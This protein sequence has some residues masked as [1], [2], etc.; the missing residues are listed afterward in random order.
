MR[1]GVTIFVFSS[2]QVIDAVPELCAE[3]E[4]SCT[5]GC[6]LNPI[7]VAKRGNLLFCIDD[8]VRN[9]DILWLWVLVFARTT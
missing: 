5:I 1:I 8:G 2:V 9:N 3:V 7:C 6:C 4:V